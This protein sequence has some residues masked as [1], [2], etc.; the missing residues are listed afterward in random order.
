VEDPA[1]YPG[2]VF[3]VIVD[4]C[5]EMSRSDRAAIQFPVAYRLVREHHF[6]VGGR[7]QR[8][9]ISLSPQEDLSAQLGRDLPSKTKNLVSPIRFCD[10][11]LKIADKKMIHQLKK[12]YKIRLAAAIGAYYH[13]QFF[14]L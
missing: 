5:F 7:L 8:K 6:A 14:Q 2:D 3:V 11:R 13:I 4:Q 1:V 9:T 12:I 10:I